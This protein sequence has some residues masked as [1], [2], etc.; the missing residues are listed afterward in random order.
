MNLLVFGKTG[1]VAAELAKAVPRGWVAQFLDRS[2]AD[3]EH[4][5]ECAA[6][7]N[8]IH[9]DIIINAAAYTAVDKAEDEEP[10]AHVINALAPAAMASAAGQIG[11]PF[12]H[13]STDYVFDGSGNTA[14]LPCDA[15][16]PLGAYG[17]TKLAGEQA[18]MR[19]V[20]QW[21][22]IR[23]SW[24]F[25]GHGSNFVRTMLHLGAKRDAINVV[26]DQFGG[27]TP[28]SAIARCLITCAQHM[29][30]RP[31][32]GIHHFAGQPAV[33]W[34]GFAEAIMDESELDCGID[35]I[36]SSGYPTPAKRPANSRLDCTS[37]EQEFG[38]SAPDWRAEL[39]HVIKELRQ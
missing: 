8:N 10:R 35:A 3:L 30:D 17:R 7:I 36:P 32:G 9:P 12:V 37:L 16:N 38:I 11:V 6:Q 21:L 14:F 15:V 29:R 25:S 27:P 13:I 22:I 5:E 18:V 4:P 31:V 2:E 1:Q 39:P 24:V 19:S 28:A 26:N 34:A 20:A 33:S 23:T